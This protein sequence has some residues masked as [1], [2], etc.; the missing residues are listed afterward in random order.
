MTIDKFVSPHNG[1]RENEIKQMLSKIC[2][3][4]V[5]ELISQTLPIVN[6]AGRCKCSIQLINFGF[7]NGQ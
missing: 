7:A 5:D 4:S 1:S 3:A 2:V 6:F